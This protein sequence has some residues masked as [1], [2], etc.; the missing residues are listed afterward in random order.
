MRFSASVLQE[1]QKEKKGKGRGL[2]AFAPSYQPLGEEAP[3]ANQIAARSRLGPLAYNGKE[4]TGIAR[5]MRGAAIKGE[6]ASKAYFLESAPEAGIVHIAAHAKADL[7]DPNFFLYRLF[8]H[9]GYPERPLQTVCPRIVQP[10]DPIRK[11]P[12]SVPA[13]PVPAPSGKGKG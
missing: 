1:M 8:Q 11:W 5:L 3:A 12:F 7:R 9:G 10:P 4:A 13:R 2:M 6:E